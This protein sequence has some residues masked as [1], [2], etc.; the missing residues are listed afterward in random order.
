MTPLK[1]FI[2]IQ[3]KQA[4]M[5]KLKKESA[6]LNKKIRSLAQEIPDLIR[7]ANLN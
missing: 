1:Q 4:E 7:A 5:D 2:Q 3:K 6:L